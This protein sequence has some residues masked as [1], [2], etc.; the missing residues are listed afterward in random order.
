MTTTIFVGLRLCLGQSDGHADPNYA[1]GKTGR[2]TCAPM[3]PGDWDRK[4][5][6]GI[7]GCGGGGI[8]MKAAAEA[9]GAA[10]TLPGLGGQGPAVVVA[11]RVAVRV[12]AVRAAGGG[13]H[14][15]IPGLGG[16]APVRA[17]VVARDSSRLGGPRPGAGVR[18]WYAILPGWRA[19]T[20][21]IGRHTDPAWRRTAG[22][23][24]NQGHRPFAR[25]S[26]EWT[27]W[28]DQP[29]NGQPL[30]QTPARRPIPAPPARC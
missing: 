9:T 25:P 4:L 17:A 23:G 28:Q 2:P 21:A 30:P 10:P 3:A 13:G 15:A 22:A 20:G 19:D 5:P 18:W 24:G 7:P 14:A 16:Q 27:L 8:S 26:R 6:L 11:V 1:A 12:V 29:Q